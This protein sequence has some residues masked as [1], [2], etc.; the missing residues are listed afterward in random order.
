MDECQHAQNPSLGC[1][2]SKEQMDLD[3]EMSNTDRHFVDHNS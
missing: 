3:L 1:S 2:T